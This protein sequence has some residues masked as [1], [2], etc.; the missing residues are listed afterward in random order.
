MEDVNDVMHQ[1]RAQIFGGI[2]EKSV[3]WVLASKE[4]SWLSR[5]AK[6]RLVVCSGVLHMVLGG[7]RCKS[8]HRKIMYLSPYVELPLTQR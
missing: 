5:V 1:K 6:I 7:G 4:D 8:Q 3:S 2:W